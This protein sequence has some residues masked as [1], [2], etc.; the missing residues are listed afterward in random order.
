VWVRIPPPT[1]NK[2][3]NKKEKKMANGLNKVMLIGNIGVDPELKFMANGDPICKFSLATNE[4]KK[5]KGEWEDHTEWHRCT[6]FGAT[7]DVIQKYARKGSKLYVEGRIQTNSWEQD[8]LKRY[9]TEIIAYKILL[10]DPPPQSQPQP[11][12][13]Y[14]PNTQPRVQPQPR[15]EVENKRTNYDDDLPF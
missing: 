4:N 1:S 15:K 5:V 8:G 11:Q 2:L 7:A 13:G 9:A 14:D 6:T 3:Y 12:R 10:L